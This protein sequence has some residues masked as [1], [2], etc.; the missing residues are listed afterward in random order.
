MLHATLTLVMALCLAAPDAVPAARVA[1]EAIEQAKDNL[2][3]LRQD[4]DA[5]AQSL[6]ALRTTGDKGLLPLLEALSA[7]P[8]AARRTFALMAVGELAG[9]D[10]ADLMH[11][12]F[13]Q[14]AGLRV[15]GLA[16]NH[17]IHHKLVADE[18]LADATACGDDSLA[19]LAAREVL[20]HTRN[21]QAL[22]ALRTLAGKDTE[23]ALLARLVLLGQGDTDQVEPVRSRLTDPKTRTEPKLV[24]LALIEKDPIASAV[25]MARH[26]QI[27]RSP[28]RD[29]A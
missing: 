6:R 19:L 23:P 29:R 18:E 25:P 26:P 24:M 17:L 1:P 7:D 22:A 10:A 4:T 12:R 16:I 28:C 5:S 27:G 20:R 13:R 15:R 9:K 2:R 8:D 11:R 14:D 3:L 21:E